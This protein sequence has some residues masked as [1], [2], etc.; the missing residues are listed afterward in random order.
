VLLFVEV[1]ALAE[2]SEALSLDAEDVHVV[3]A[4]GR[5]VLLK[6]TSGQLR[7]TR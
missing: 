7:V 5:R 4:D 2:G 6:V 3:A 1:E